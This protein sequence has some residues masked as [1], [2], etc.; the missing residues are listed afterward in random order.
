VRVLMVVRDF[1]PWVGGTERQAFKLSRQLQACGV[2]VR[3]V[4]GWWF[5]DTPAH[6]VIDGLPVDRNLTCWRMWNIKGLRKFGGYLYMITL[7][8]YLL[9]RRKE[10]DL[11]HV[12]MLNY[13]T[14][15]AV[16]AGRWLGKPVLVKVANG[17]RASDIG[18]MRANEIPGARAMLPTALKADCWVAISQE[19]AQDLRR[20]GIPSARIVNIPNAV[21]VEDVP[22]KRSYAHDGPLTLVYTGRLHPQKGLDTLLQAVH[23]AAARRPEA[24]LRLWILGTGEAAEHLARLRTSLQL[25]SIVHFWGQV[26]DVSPYLAQADLFVL[27]SYAEGMS[28][29]LLEAM[30]C[31]LP[32]VATAVGGNVDLIREGETGLLVEPGDVQA[33]CQAIL[34][35]AADESLRERL[36]RGARKAVDRCYALPH[37]AARYLE[38]YQS[39]ADPRRERTS[40]VER[41]PF[42]DVEVSE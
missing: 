20:E 12:H 36:G 22:Q 4:T 39:L 38:L 13:H 18:K 9:S 31:G 29:A 7:F 37:V 11:I 24:L 1:L 6:E 32:C 41:A 16:L 42:P 10:Y 33:L 28:N 35:L 40:H 15:V 3:I 5:K 21:D 26:D 27:P 25:D 30:A 19:I 14:F 8:G 2:S 34:A 17:G 23:L